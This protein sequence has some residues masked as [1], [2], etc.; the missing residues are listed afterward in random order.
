MIL[1]YM[2]LYWLGRATHGKQ[3]IGN[4]PDKAKLKRPYMVIVLNVPEFSWPER[5]SSG[6]PP[7]ARPGRQGTMAG[8]N[9]F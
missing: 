4:A 1:S 8:P 2:G 3:F 5:R 6:P 9:I 7:G